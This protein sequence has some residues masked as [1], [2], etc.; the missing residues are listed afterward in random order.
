MLKQLN[1]QE[2]LRN[3]SDGFVNLFMIVLL[4]PIIFEG[5]YNMKKK[6]HFYKNLGTIILI[7]F[8][9]TFVSAVLT[10]MGVW[11]LGFI[12]TTKLS[13]KET[14]AF[15]SLISATDPVAVLAVFKELNADDHLYSLI[16]GESILNDAVSIVMYRTIVKAD[17][18]IG[19]S[20]SKHIIL[21][22]YNFFVIIFGSFLIGMIL[23]L[24]V[25]TLLKNQ[26]AVV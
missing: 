7:A 8:L 21:S 12:G 18:A 22:C 10:G 25:A 16:F 14:W 3:V 13:L 4:P 1:S 19:E 5:G 9:G 6:H 17:D 20:Y 24:V 23:A 26:Y 2:Y 11:L 15:G